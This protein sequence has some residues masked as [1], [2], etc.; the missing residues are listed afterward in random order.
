MKQKKFELSSSCVYGPVLRERLRSEVSL[1]RAVLS[2]FL[3]PDTRLCGAIAA[4]PKFPS[5]GLHLELPRD[6][7]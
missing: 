2:S 1:T 4:A 3:T 6:T 5:P 7:C